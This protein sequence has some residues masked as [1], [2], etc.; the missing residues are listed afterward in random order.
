MKMQHTIATLFLEHFTL[1][2]SEI[3]SIH[4]REV[5]VDTRLFAAMDRLH[6]IRSECRALLEGSDAGGGGG[7]RAG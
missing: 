7:M 1:S 3:E 4:S 5:P 6:V 2:P